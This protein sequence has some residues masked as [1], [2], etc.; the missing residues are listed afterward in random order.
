MTDSSKMIG[1]KAVS[2]ISDGKKIA[3]HTNKNIIIGILDSLDFKKYPEL[4]TLI[5]S[6]NEGKN[7]YTMPSSKFII[8][9]DV[10]MIENSKY[11]SLP[12]MIIFTES[13]LGI[14]PVSPG[15]ILEDK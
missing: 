10:T 8:I 2:D 12:F 7:K 4:K 11:T 15:W 1:L 14:S 5:E 6:I 13:I 9:Q 3:I